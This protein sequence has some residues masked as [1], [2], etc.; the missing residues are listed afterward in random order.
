MKDSLFNAFLIAL[1]VQDKKTDFATAGDNVSLG[2]NGIDISNI[3]YVVI[4]NFKIIYFILFSFLFLADM[5]H[6]YVI[7]KNLSLLLIDLLLLLL[8]LN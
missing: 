4:Y 2:L 3:S 6:F 7:L 1:E 5:V 8:L